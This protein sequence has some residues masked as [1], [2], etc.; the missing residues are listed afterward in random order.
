[1]AYTDAEL[2]SFLA[3][4][5]GANRTQKQAIS[6]A[7]EQNLKCTPKTVNSAQ[8]A[9]L[10]QTS[11]EQRTE[12][13]RGGW[14]AS[15]QWLERNF[16]EFREPKARCETRSSIPIREPP[17]L[18]VSSVNPTPP[19]EQ[20]PDAIA[21]ESSQSAREA[22]PDPRPSLAT[23]SEAERFAAAVETMPANVRRFFQAE[24][25][26]VSPRQLESAQDRLEREARGSFGGWC[27]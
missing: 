20:E 14:R 3:Q 11:R 1:M 26:F 17:T 27:G 19:V 13:E 5:R 12:L 7:S 24:E 8:M 2:A 25:S 16:E 23:V 15:A 9:Q 21:P 6:G 18:P 4:C 22:L 10:E